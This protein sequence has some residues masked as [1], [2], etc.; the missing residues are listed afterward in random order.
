MTHSLSVMTLQWIARELSI[1]RH[2]IDLANEKGR[3]AE[4]PS[5]Y[6]LISDCVLL[7]ENQFYTL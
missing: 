6:T 3:R 4:Y 5:E 2:R 1:L 7:L